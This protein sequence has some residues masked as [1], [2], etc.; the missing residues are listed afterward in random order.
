MTIELL[1]GDSHETWSEFSWTTVEPAEA[2][3]L[4]NFNP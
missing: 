4:K 3:C 1:L 2:Y